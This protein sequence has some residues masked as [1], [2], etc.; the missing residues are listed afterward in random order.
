MNI[1]ASQHLLEKH[2]LVR[3]Y[4]IALAKIHKPA[5]CRRNLKSV[6]YSWIQQA[7]ND[8]NSC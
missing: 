7:R 2:D 6:G 8:L 3:I 1:E 5:S 4:D